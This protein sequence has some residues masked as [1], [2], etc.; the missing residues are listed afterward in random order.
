MRSRALLDLAVIADLEQSD[1]SEDVAF[2]AGMARWIGGPL[3]ELGCGAGRLAIPLARAGADIVAIDISMRMLKGFG[4]RLAHESPKTRSRIKLVQA[5]MRR[6]SLKRK[7]LK[8]LF[9][10]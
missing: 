8:R 2:F 4:G 10:A 1:E 3:L 9:R 5:D 7:S 6:F